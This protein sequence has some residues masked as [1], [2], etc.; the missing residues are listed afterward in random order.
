MKTLAESMYCARYFQKSK[1]S[2]N[3]RVNLWAG[4]F[5]SNPQTKGLA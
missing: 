5:F 2:N 4:S 3:K 1:S